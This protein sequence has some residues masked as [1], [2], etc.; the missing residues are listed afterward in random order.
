MIDPNTQ[1]NEPVL[2]R[3]DLNDLGI[4]GVAEAK[5]LLSRAIEKGSD[6]EKLVQLQEAQI[7]AT[8]A[9]TE[10]S[11]L[12]LEQRK[13]EI[14]S[15]KFDELNSS[16]IVKL[17]DGASEEDQRKIY[18]DASARFGAHNAQLV[19]TG[20]EIEKA[21]SRQIHRDHKDYEKIT[22]IQKANDQIFLAVAALGGSK[23]TMAEGG[24][25][26]DRDVLNQVKDM[27]KGSS[28]DT[29]AIN[30]A[31]DSI[32]ATDGLEWVPTMYSS[33]LLRD[34]YLSLQVASTFR[35]INMP[36]ATY[37]L[38]YLTKRTRAYK[39][40]QATAASPFTNLAKVHG[41]D[42][43]DLTMTAVKLGFAQFVSGELREDSIIDV[44]AEMYDETVWGL[45]SAIDD[46]CLNG[47]LLL[48]DLDN[49][50][51]DTNR[52]WNNT[53]DAGDDIRLNTGADDA[54]NAWNGIRKLTN[55]GAR[56]DGG[57][58]APNLANFR[59]IRKLMGKYGA[60]ASNLIAF[61]NPASQIDFLNL[62]EVLTLEKYGPN[63]TVLVGEI[64]RLDS[65]PLVQSEYQRN[66]YNASGVFD[67]ATKTRTIVSLVHKDGF[68][69]GDRR[70]PTVQSGDNVLADQSYIVTTNRVAF[71]KRFQSADNIA[72]ELYNVAK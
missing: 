72:A 17:F 31:L 14:E 50:G 41:L 24:I 9:L 5:A 44:V 42:T 19:L 54:R 11:K 8:K 46:A 25:R 16:N 58:V 40:G 65:I 69:F 64:G 36:S 67:Q 15:N 59:A 3:K 38:P 48:N 35:R 23:A 21:V 22:A 4:E 62:P 43:A 52:L 60:T 18:E 68:L 39:M 10:N 37:K 12:L 57:N 32:T 7:E 61:I 49:A 63:A 45:A 33:N 27:F 66:D 70:M 2:T 20:T 1:P 26:I 47:S 53:A 71:M 56:L 51:S 13:E 55:S 29:K 34:V 6:I 28:N 30:D